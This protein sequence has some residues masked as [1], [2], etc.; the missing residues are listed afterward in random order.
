MAYNKN[1]KR[2]YF[3]KF[4]GMKRASK[5]L[6]ENANR[7]KVKTLKYVSLFMRRSLN[8]F[9]GAE[10]NI[11]WLPVPTVLLKFY[12]KGSVLPGKS[13]TRKTIRLQATTIG[14]PG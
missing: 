2:V 8:F 6:M 11:Q 13:R 14:L 12:T 9:S 3:T 1:K 5:K 10:N 7:Q 4:S